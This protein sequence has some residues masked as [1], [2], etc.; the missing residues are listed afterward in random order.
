ME[1]SVEEEFSFLDLGDCNVDDRNYL[2]TLLQQHSSAVIDARAPDLYQFGT[3]DPV[4]TN[5]S[6][7]IAFAWTPVPDK[8]GDDATGASAESRGIVFEGALHQPSE[9]VNRKTHGPMPPGGTKIVLPG[10]ANNPFALGHMQVPPI[11]RGNRGQ[12]PMTNQDVNIQPSPQ[13]VKVKPLPQAPASVVPNYPGPAS[14][15]GKYNTPHI[16]RTT[17]FHQNFYYC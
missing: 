4:S 11:A 3:Q 10:K 5:S 14:T 17:P 9:E 16:F 2:H 1:P 8:I 12:Q 6:G 7:D 15:V 13:P